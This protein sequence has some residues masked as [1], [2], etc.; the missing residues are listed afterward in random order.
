MK[1]SKI[2]LTLLVLMSYISSLQAKKCEL[3]EAIQQQYQARKTGYL[4]FTEKKSGSLLQDSVFRESALYY[5]PNG[6]NK[7]V[8]VAGYDLNLRTITYDYDWIKYQDSIYIAVKKKETIKADPYSKKLS[9]KMFGSIQKLP[10]MESIYFF[11]ILRLNGVDCQDEDEQFWYL[12]NENP[13]FKYRLQ[14][15]KRDSL[16]TWITY[17]ETRR[18][19]FLYESIHF[20]EQNFDAEALAANPPLPL[21]PDHWRVQG[22]QAPVKKKPVPAA[23]TLVGT[24]APDWKYYSTE[25]D[26]LSLSDF[27]GQYVLLD[28]WYIGCVPCALAM[29]GLQALSEE[30]DQ[31]K[32]RVIGVETHTRSAESVAAFLEKRGVNYTSLIAARSNISQRYKVKGY[33][34]FFLID[35]EGVIIH[36]QRGYSEGE[37][38]KLRK[39]IKKKLK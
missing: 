4:T 26:S 20:H 9:Q 35:P 27:A 19:E 13:K 2:V 3:L 25:S 8:D 10:V 32:L 34:T 31:S 7:A 17:K 16:I 30:F 33:P 21:A 5:Q 14:V 15:R 1:I 18:G 12:G 37:I 38:W 23:A 6:L 39:L 11:T 24:Q 22:Y 36:V 29:P 28:F